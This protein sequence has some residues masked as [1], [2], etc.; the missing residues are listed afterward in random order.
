MNA[1]YHFKFSMLSIAL[2]LTSTSYVKAGCMG[3]G[4]WHEHPDSATVAESMIINDGADHFGF[5]D[6]TRLEK[7]LPRLAHKITAAIDHVTRE[8][9]H[10][11]RDLHVLLSHSSGACLVMTPDEVVWQQN[12]DRLQRSR[13]AATLCACC[14]AKLATPVAA[15][16]ISAAERK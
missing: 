9:L 8:A 2:F 15:I 12:I 7:R 4:D 5:N 1:N 16:D 13:F 14:A 10:S 6:F 3:D 11:K